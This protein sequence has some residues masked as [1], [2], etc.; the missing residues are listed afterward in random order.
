MDLAIFG[1]GFPNTT[2]SIKPI[3]HIFRKEIT[4]TFI[5]LHIPTSKDAVQSITFYEIIV[6]YSQKKRFFPSRTHS[7]DF[8]IPFFYFSIQ[9]SRLLWVNSLFVMSDWFG[10]E[11]IS[12]SDC[13]LNQSTWPEW[14]GSGIGGSGGGQTTMPKS[15]ATFTDQPWQFRRPDWSFKRN[16]Q[17]GCLP[18]TSIVIEK[19]VHQNC[20]NRITSSSEQKVFRT[21]PQISLQTFIFISKV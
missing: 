6:V 4:S 21:T 11:W 12:R 3:M 1:I 20:K 17:H 13:L 7:K 2:S 10:L 8:F 15:H 19:V 9:S 5:I 14:W 18:E 16:Y